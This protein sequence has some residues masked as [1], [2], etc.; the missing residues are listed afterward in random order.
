MKKC[1]WNIVQIPADKNGIITPEAVTALLTPDTMLAAV[2][3]VNNETG[4]IQ[5]IY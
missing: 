1:G 3:A 4:S 5:P 2:M